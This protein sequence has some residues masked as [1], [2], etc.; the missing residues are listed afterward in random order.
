M[1]PDFSHSIIWS[2]RASTDGGIVSPIALA[3]LRLITSSNFVAYS[4]GWS[5]GS[6]PFQD[7]VDID[8]AA[9]VEIVVIRAVAHKAA[10]VARRMTISG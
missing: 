5:P 7:L 1:I 6:A 4:T 10:I 9:P 8:G 3:V 2:A